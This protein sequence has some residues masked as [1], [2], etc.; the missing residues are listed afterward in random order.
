MTALL[1]GVVLVVALVLAG[2]AGLGLV[3]GLLR[4]SGR[5]SGER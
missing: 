4:I 2:A 1:S 3:I 5:P